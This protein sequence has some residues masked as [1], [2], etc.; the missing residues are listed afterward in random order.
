MRENARG[1]GIDTQS[2]TDDVLYRV[3]SLYVDAAQAART[4]EFADREVEAMTGAAQAV[5]ARV[6]QGYELPIEG[7]RA[8]LNRGARPAAGRRRRSDQDYTEAALATVLG[9]PD[10]DRV[11]AAQRISGRGNQTA[12]TAA[13]PAR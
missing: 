5:Q 12:G 7:K 8:E 1:A 2:K 6:S 4:A 13:E 10:T 11:R 9:F 3:A